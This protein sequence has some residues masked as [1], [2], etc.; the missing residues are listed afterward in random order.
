[1]RYK[2]ALDTVQYTLPCISEKKFV[3]F[4]E[5]LNFSR[6]CILIHEPLG[7]HPSHWHC[8][9]VR[10]ESRIKIPRSK[11]L[12]LASHFCVT[13][14][15]EFFESVVVRKILRVNDKSSCLRKRRK[16]HAEFGKKKE[17][18]RV[19]H[20]FFLLQDFV[21]YVELSPSPSNIMREFP[22]GIPS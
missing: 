17:T 14:L 1:M 11:T 12:H 13:H 20:A 18:Q 21:V 2:I 22:S 16:R 5:I 3:L 19:R 7:R 8:E 4:L 6:P 15:C 10:A 9:I